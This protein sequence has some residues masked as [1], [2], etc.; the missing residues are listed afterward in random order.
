VYILDSTE[1]PH[2]RISRIAR[3]LES[4]GIDI[5]H[6]EIGD[7]ELDVDRR[8]IDAMYRAALEGYTHYGYSRGIP[9]LRRS[10]ANY[11]ND[12]LGLD[13]DEDNI[14]LTPGGKVAIYLALRLLNKRRIGILEPIWGLYYS[15][16]KV[17]NLDII[18][19]RT[20]FEDG[21]LPKDDALKRFEDV[22]LIS[23]VN[24]SNPTGTILSIDTQD[25][26]VEIA[27]DNDIYILA[28]EIYFDLIYRDIKFKSFLEYGYENTL[29]IFSFSKNYA[30]TGFRVGFVVSTNKELIDR[31]S[32]YMR[33]VI[34]GV[35]PFIQFAALEALKNRD[36]VDNNRRFYREQTRYL[37]GELKKLGF[38]MVEP[39]AGIYIFPKVPNGID[40]VKFTEKLLTIGRVA[41]S[42][43]TGFGD[44][45]EFIRFTTAIKR[46]KLATAIERIRYTLENM[47]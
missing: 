35:P 22:D 12:K 34:G 3:E 42:P 32:K 17:L 23:I 5:I 29:S 33:L 25:K 45:P 21:W 30:M 11:L 2:Y 27:M 39:S 24:P 28:D 40:G 47:D 14:C 10:I 18:N 38:D 7:P 13:L 9:G 6:M 43:G 19:V 37:S 36:I 44:Y 16:S 31:F 1:P 41:V 4:K 8:I 15:F 26:I 20:E 46:D